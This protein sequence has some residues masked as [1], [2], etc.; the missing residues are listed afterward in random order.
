M[1]QQVTKCIRAI[2]DNKVTN[3]TK[4]QKWWSV[5]MKIEC[6][7]ENYSCKQVQ[8]FKFQLSQ[9]HK[10]TRPHSRS[11]LFTIA[12]SNQKQMRNQISMPLWSR[13]PKTSSGIKVHKG[14]P[15]QNKCNNKNTMHLYTISVKMHEDLNET[16]SQN[17][18][19]VTKTVKQHCPKA[20]RL[21]QWTEQGYNPKP[22]ANWNRQFF[23]NRTIQHLNSNM[24]QCISTMQSSRLPRWTICL[25]A[26]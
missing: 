14:S 19:Q 17:N 21:K 5:H 16:Q 8:Q 1:C 20:T 12:V 9:R 18:A 11:N 22:Q 7:N 23:Q 26:K 4:V 6:H 24:T 3:Q 15:T 10:G 13:Q 25:K 2:A